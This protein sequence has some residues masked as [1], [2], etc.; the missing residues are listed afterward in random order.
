MNCAGKPIDILR[1]INE[2]AG[3][4]PDEEI[5]LYEVCFF[6]LFYSSGNSVFHRSLYGN[7]FISFV[8]FI[9]VKCVF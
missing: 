5:D 2:L 8:K 7:E 9:I 3:F 6:M 4:D 1:N